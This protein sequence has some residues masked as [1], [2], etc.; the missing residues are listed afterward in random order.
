MLHPQRTLSP[1]HPVPTTL[2][3]WCAPPPRRS[4]CP[5]L[6]P[7]LVPTPVHP[8]T[9]CPGDT[10]PRPSPRPRGV[11]AGSGSSPVPA[12]GGGPRA[13]L[14][15]TCCYFYSLCGRIRCCAELQPPR[16]RGT[17]TGTGTARGRA[18]HGVP[19]VLSRRRA[20]PCVPH[21]C[22]EGAPAFRARCGPPPPRATLQVPPAGDEPRF[23]TQSW[24][25][26]P[27]AGLCHPEP[28]FA[29]QSQD[30]PARA[31]ICHLE[32]CFAEL[33]RV[34]PGGREAGPWLGATRVNILLERWLLAHGHPQPLEHREIR[35]TEPVPSSPFLVPARRQLPSTPPRD[36]P[37]GDEPLLR[38]LATPLSPCMRTPWLCPLGGAGRGALDVPPLPAWKVQPWCRALPGGTSPRF[39]RGDVLCPVGFSMGKISKSW[40]RARAGGHSPG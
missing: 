33:C 24:T 7:H 3:P 14:P 11:G 35:G 26:S 37:G 22:L 36:I 29:A 31:E 19:T 10:A 9:L 39:P 34:V 23:V 20:G 27:R 12:G 17:G 18:R 38:L 6:C 21:V 15:S 25:L 40:G 8:H 4:V 2:H 13:L 32:P 16:H 28:R 30:L 1:C 5:Q